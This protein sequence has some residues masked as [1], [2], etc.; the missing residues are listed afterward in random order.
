MNHS[1][2]FTLRDENVPAIVAQ[3]SNAGLGHLPVKLCPSAP[4]HL[5]SH[6]HGKIIF[7]KSKNIFT[8]FLQH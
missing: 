7:R 2:V 8:F 3:L 5:N 1:G 6:F 4:L